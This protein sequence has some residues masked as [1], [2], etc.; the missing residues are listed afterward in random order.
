MRF[1]RGNPPPPHRMSGRRLL[2]TCVGTRNFSGSNFKEGVSPGHEKKPARTARLTDG[3]T[4]KASA[5]E[6][7]R[8]KNIDPP[9]F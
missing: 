6:V 2:G 3:K 7:A 5:P 8:L 4:D 1:G 9:A